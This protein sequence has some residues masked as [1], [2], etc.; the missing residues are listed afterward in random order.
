MLITAIAPWFGSKRTL[1]P[2]IVEQLGRHAY[3]FE[4]CA[5]S[6]SVLLAKEPSEHEVVCDLHGALTNLAW[7]V[8]RDDVAPDL[9]DRLQR[10]MYDD[11]I[12]KASKDWLA[13]NEAQLVKSQKL[14][15]DD[16]NDDWAY[17]YFIASWMGRNGVS[18]TARV[19]YQIATRWTKGG[20]SGPG[21]F[22]AAVESIPAWHDR[23][24]NVHVLRRNVFDVLPK[25]QDDEGLSIY[26][27]PPYLPGTIAGNSKYL[28]NFTDE[29]HK[30]LAAAL[31]R[32]ERARVVVS[33]YADRQLKELYPGWTWLDCSRQKHLHVQNKRGMGRKEAPEVLLINGPAYADSTKKT[34][35]IPAEL[36]A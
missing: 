22:R 11:E 10:V 27:D 2:T 14:S 7:C 32:F 36:F 21:R 25:L 3:Y 30:R 5:G 19:N 34:K 29:D 12:Y 6:M 24:R 4:A 35:P 28:C 17:H 15:A 23:L 16:P 31:R 9:Y 18:G 33:Y 13:D 8:Q 1:A 20:G 26:A